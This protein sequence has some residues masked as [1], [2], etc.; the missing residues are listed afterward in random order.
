MEC[1]LINKPTLEYVDN[2]IGQ[3]Y[4]KGCYTDENKK[5]NRINRVA[6]V[7]KH[8]SVLEFEDVVFEITASTKV[9]LEMTRH[10]LANYACKSSRYTLDKGEI[11]F[12]ST[13]NESV[14][15]SLNDF[16]KIIEI[17]RNHGVKNDILSLMLPQAYQ[18]RWLVK[19]NYRSLQ[20]FLQLRLDK[21]AHFHIRDVANAMYE[22]IPSEHKYLFEEYINGTDKES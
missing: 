7:H 8:S 3:C 16:K 2:A 17:H 18:Y 9:L 11:I 14:D 15:D 21:H 13:G 12:E 19:M 5:H 10:R 6:N 20:N 1:K 4:D 22:Q